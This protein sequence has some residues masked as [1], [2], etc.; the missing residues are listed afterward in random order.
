MTYQPGPQQQPYQPQPAP[1]GPQMP[2]GWTPPPPSGWST[3]SG[4]TRGIIVAVLIVVGGI[5][6][7]AFER[8]TAANP[9]FDVRISSCTSTSLTATVGLSVHNTSK[10][11]KSA[12]V[13]VE[14]RDAAGTRLDT[15]TAYVRD[16]APG[17]TAR[18]DESTILDATTAGTVFCRVLKVS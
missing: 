13:E 12:R 7:I 17:D 5:G 1:T 6:W 9:A 2:P 11:T 14:Y 8:Y 10:T 18:H 15:D 16:I 3:W 4:R